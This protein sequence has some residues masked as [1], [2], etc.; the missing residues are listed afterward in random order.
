MDNTESKIQKTVVKEKVRRCTRFDCNGM[1]IKESTTYT[2]TE[3]DS[4]TEVECYCNT[5]GAL[6]KP[7]IV[8]PTA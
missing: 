3:D 6:Y 5:C 4:V 1:I 2:L 7:E 8:C